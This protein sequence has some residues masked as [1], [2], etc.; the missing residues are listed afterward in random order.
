MS[1]QK[2]PVNH[3]K[4]RGEEI[5]YHRVNADVNGNPRY[6]T[7]FLDLGVKL[8]DYG[9]IQGLEKYR[10]KWFGGGYV[11]QSYNLE[12]TL[13]WAMETVESYYNREGN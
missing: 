5:P 12:D 7:H 1:N 6:V 9:K 11:F 10:A 8:E 3:I 4:V 13:D 2:Y